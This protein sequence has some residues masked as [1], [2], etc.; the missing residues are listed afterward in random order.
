MFT[1][2]ICDIFKN[3]FF[4]RI[5]PVAVSASRVSNFSV[6]ANNDHAFSA[7]YYSQY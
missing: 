6:I 2:E 3:S 7:E 1:C 5:P 4:Y